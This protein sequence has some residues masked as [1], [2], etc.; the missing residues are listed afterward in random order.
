M[1]ILLILAVAWSLS[2]WGETSAKAAGSWCSKCRNGLQQATRQR[3]VHG[4]NWNPHAVLN[5][6]QRSGSRS[7]GSWC[8]RRL[9][10][11][12]QRVKDILGMG[13]RSK[14]KNRVLPYGRRYPVGV[15]CLKRMGYRY[16]SRC[17]GG[18]KSSRRKNLNVGKKR[19]YR[20]S[21]RK[22]YPVG[23]KYVKKYGSKNP[24]KSR[25]RYPSRVCYRKYYGYRYGKGQKS[26][27]K[28]KVS[29]KWW[30]KYQRRKYHQSKNQSRRCYGY[31]RT[32]REQ[33]RMKAASGWDYKNNGALYE[34]VNFLPKDKMK[35][36]YGAV[37]G[38]GR[39][40]GALKKGLVDEAEG[41]SADVKIFES[42]NMKVGGSSHKIWMD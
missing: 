16:R 36:G 25:M 14:C 9:E 40:M 7:Y 32:R 23:V 4:P 11:R 21:N 26:S 38:Y 20:I 39:K 8:M 2:L 28:S 33:L 10:S 34:P 19:L 24:S 18:K 27:G 12:G 1:K 22:Q 30:L 41:G 31:P 15:Y 3:Y 37:S 35:W 17:G 5:C 42:G 29:K 6:G 13:Q